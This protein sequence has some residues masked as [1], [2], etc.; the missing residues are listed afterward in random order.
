MDYEEGWEVKGERPEERHLSPNWYYTKHKIRE[1]ATSRQIKKKQR[2]LIKRVL[3]LMEAEPPGKVLDLGCGPGNTMEFLKEVGYKPFGIDIVSGM[4]KRAKNKGLS[5]LI[6]DMRYLKDYYKKGE[7][8]YVI[9]ISALQWLSKDEES[10]RKVRDGIDHVL[11]KK[12]KLGIQFYP[13]SEAE[14]R[15]VGRIFKKK[16]GGQIVIDNPENPKKRTI[17]IV[18]EKG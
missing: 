15:E 11:R 3:E 9:S 1:Y 17:F 7:F 13:K 6:G 12:G 5:A 10:L 2:K 18:M 8:N 14:M 16:F 4:V